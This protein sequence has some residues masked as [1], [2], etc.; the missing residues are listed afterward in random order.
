MPLVPCLPLAPQGFRFWLDEVLW[1]QGRVAVEVIDE[2]LRDAGG[3]SQLPM[4]PGSQGK[5]WQG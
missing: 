1:S 4:L 5:P 3:C 2:V